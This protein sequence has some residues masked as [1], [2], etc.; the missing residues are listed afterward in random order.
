MA[1][2][3]EWPELGERLTNALARAR[4]LVPNIVER[5]LIDGSTDELIAWLARQFLNGKRIGYAA[6][7]TLFR[8][9]QFIRP[10]VARAWVDEAVDY[11]AVDTHTTAG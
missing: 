5:A 3:S 4:N 10:N 1:I 7:G 2:R 11:A 6:Q 9:G 8:F